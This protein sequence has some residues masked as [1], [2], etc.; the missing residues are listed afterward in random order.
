[1]SNKRTKN[2]IWDLVTLNKTIHEEEP[3]NENI[4]K[5]RRV[6]LNNSQK[7][8]SVQYKT[9]ASNKKQIQIAKYLSIPKNYSIPSEYSSFPILRSTS[10]SNSFITGL[11]PVVWVDASDLTSILRDSANNVYQILDK[12]GNNNHLYQNTLVNQ[13][14]YHNGGLLFNSNQYLVGTN[15]FTQSINNISIFVILKQY[16]QSTNQGIISGTSSTATSDN[17]NTNAWALTGSDNST[18]QYKFITNNTS[19]KNTND[20]TKTIPYGIYEI[21]INNNVGS[22]YYDGTLINTTTFTGLGNFT[23]LVLADLPANLSFDL[24]LFC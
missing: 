10:Y 12:S 6:I 21:I 13:P 2:S 22:L 20:I 5:K 14:K 4:N 1:M 15:T 16:N 24:F 17:N 9:N 3:T 19:I 11:N 8:K 18:S 23:N 7:L